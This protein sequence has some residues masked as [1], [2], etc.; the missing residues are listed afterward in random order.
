MATLAIENT[1]PSPL[2]LVVEDEPYIRDLA[3]DALTNCGYRTVAA[4]CAAEA[5]DQLQTRHSDV[6]LLFTDVKMPGDMDGV[7]LAF[8]VRSRWP[9]IGL[10]VVSAYFDPKVSRLPMGCGFLAKPYR[11]AELNA[12]VEQQLG[13]LGSSRRDHI[14]NSL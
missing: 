10:I 3:I 9:T 7:E 8:T 6:D 12:L 4:A 1:S 13:F 11:F 5:L 14:T 2:I